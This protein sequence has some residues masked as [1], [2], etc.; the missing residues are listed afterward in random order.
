MF[1][2]RV[3]LVLKHPHPSR[4]GVCLVLTFGWLEWY[5]DLLDTASAGAVGKEGKRK[6]ELGLIR[7][8][9]ERAERETEAK[10]R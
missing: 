6:S 2:G 8:G 9:S 4:L 5:R 1:P 7:A 10:G 3:S